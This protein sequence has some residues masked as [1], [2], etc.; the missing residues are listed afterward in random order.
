MAV[1]QQFGNVK[2][3]FNTANS[4]LKKMDD[5]FKQ[6]MTTLKNQTGGISQADM[7]NIQFEMGQYNAMV[8][9]FANVTKGLT[10]ILKSLAQ[11]TS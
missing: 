10:E 2:E 3:M 5:E 9:S 7:L 1:V 4:T 11:K 6:T 8:E